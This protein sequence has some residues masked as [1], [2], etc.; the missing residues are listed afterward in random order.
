V[1]R[2]TLLRYFGIS[3]RAAEFAAAFV[4]QDKLFFSV[5]NVDLVLVLCKA[6]GRRPSARLRGGFNARSCRFALS[7]GAAAYAAQT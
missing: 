3:T 7:C 2:I 1:S 6:M 4:G 5:S